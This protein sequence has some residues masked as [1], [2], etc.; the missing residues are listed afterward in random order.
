MRRLL[1][2][3]CCHEGSEG[4]RGEISRWEVS[5]GGEER[6]EDEDEVIDEGEERHSPPPVGTSSS[7]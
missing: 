6:E 1:F 7:Q 5:E 3:R 4:E 2:I